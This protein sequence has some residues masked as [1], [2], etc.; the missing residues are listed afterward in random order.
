MFHGRAA[1]LVAQGIGL[2][3]H[4][5]REVV[6]LDELADLLHEVVRPRH[7]AE[8]GDEEDEVAGE[9][10]EHDGFG[11]TAVLPEGQRALRGSRGGRFAVDRPRPPS[12][13]TST[14]VEVDCGMPHPLP[15]GDL[16]YAVFTAV[17]AL[18]GAPVK[19]IH[20]HVGVPSGLA[21]TTT[22]TVLD[23]LLEKGLVRRAQRGRAVWYWPATTRAIV[24]R[25]TL[26]ALFQRMRGDPPEP[27]MATLVDAVADLDPA[28]L[29]ELARRVRERKQRG[30]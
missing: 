25:E 27:L 6:V 9:A 2:P 28:L 16:E 10:A 19:D 21:Y 8:D 17:A 23:R 22:S 30:S 24:D 18:G 15:G 4:G 29:D 13:F 7:Q 20:A 12:S 5:V 14:P 1:V 3:G 11:G 26:R